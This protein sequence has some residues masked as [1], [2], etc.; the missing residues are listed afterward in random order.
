MLVL[1]MD[2]NANNMAAVMFEYD[3]KV[4]VAIDE[5][6]GLADTSAMCRAV[7]AKYP[8]VPIT[9]HPDAAGRAVSSKGA[10]L[11]DFSILR[12]EGFIIKSPVQNPPI[13]ERVNSVNLAF[14]KG[15][16]FVDIE[17]CEHLTDALEQQ[18]YLNGL[19]DKTSGLDHILDAFGYAIS[20]IFPAVSRK[21]HLK[22][23]SI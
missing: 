22:T 11:S 9:V 15:K 3:G 13:K 12:K 5:F 21:T 17:R 6:V 14:E 19:P 8:D 16:L 7:K 4:L 20:Y 23:V 10:T 1:G 18:V 2:F